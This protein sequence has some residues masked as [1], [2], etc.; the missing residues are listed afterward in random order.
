[1]IAAF[2]AAV[3]P[4]DAEALV[5]D[6]RLFRPTPAG[7]H[8]IESY[9]ATKEK[10]R[11]EMEADAMALLLRGDARRAWSRMGRYQMAQMFPDPKWTR[12]VPE[13]LLQ[14][15]ACLM[16][17]S[18]DDLPLDEAQRLAALLIELSGLERITP[19]DGLRR[20]IAN[21]RELVQGIMSDMHTLAV[22]LRPASLGRLGLMP[23]LRA[24]VQELVGQLGSSIEV[25]VVGPHAALDPDTETMVYRIAQE[26]AIN[27]VHYSRA[28]HISI[29]G[30]QRDGRFVL[31]IEDN[32]VGFDT[33][34]AA[35]S[36]GVGIVSMRERAE[37]V[38]GA[39]S[40]ESTPARGTSVFIEV[41]LAVK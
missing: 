8:R 38:G 28:K 5:A 29:V 24:F 32:G 30:A 12:G 34:A 9:V 2:I 6:V 17:L 10:A 33:E 40:I 23:A 41:P 14:E 3:S 15:A 21:M 20:R 26:A 27:A 37:M 35:A 11:Q 36:G 18:Y 1:M 19:D 16:R 7:S 39:V 31:V 13:P 22:D 25:E 4:A